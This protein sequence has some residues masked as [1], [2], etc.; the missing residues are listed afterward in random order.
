[1]GQNRKVYRA[2]LGFYDTVVA[3]Q[4]QESALAAWGSTQNLFRI[5]LA[6]PTTDPDAVKAAMAKPGVVLKRPA[7]SAVAFSEHPPLPTIPGKKASRSAE[8]GSRAQRKTTRPKNG[9][10]RAQ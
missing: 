6:K 4:S 10:R 3:A 7:G 8:K 2:H 9:R 1:M 5:G